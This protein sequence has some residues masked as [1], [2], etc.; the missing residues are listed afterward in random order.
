MTTPTGRASDPNEPPTVRQLSPP[1]LKAM[2]DA[3]LPL[4]L[5]DVRTQEERAVARIDGSRL[6]DITAV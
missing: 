6:L 4:L 2:M 5:V 1:E 3:G